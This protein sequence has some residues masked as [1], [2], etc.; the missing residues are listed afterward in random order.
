MA[1]TSS[2]LAETPAIGRPRLADTIGFDLVAV[3]DYRPRGAS[4]NDR[5]PTVQASFEAALPLSE[6]LGIHAGAWG[7]PLDR[8]AGLGSAEIDLTA[9]LSGT[10]GDIGW[11][12]G[13]AR[14][15]FPSAPQSIDFDQLT[16]SVDL[17]VGRN[18]MTA[19]IVRSDYDLG[20]DTWIYLKGKAPLGR[21]GV[22]LTGS[23]GLE[24]GRNWSDKLDWSIGVELVR[25][26]ATLRLAYV[27]TNAFMPASN[28]CDN[29]AG[30]AILLTLGLRAEVER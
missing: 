26:N 30:G 12:A 1:I 9:G 13:Y 20:R 18:R 17:P 8:D 5:R 29:L 28:E 14:I 6:T 15:M 7:S 25:S 16:A 2:A 23:V 19:G 21:S 22:G 10:A 4:Y 11:R 3:S 24:N 27:D